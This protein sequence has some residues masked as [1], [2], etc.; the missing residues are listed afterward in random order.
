MRGVRIE[1]DETSS[2]E[3][4]VLADGDLV[5]VTNL[6]RNAAEA[7][8]RTVHLTL[9]ADAARVR[10]EVSDDGPGIPSELLPRI[11]D[12]GVS[13]KADDTGTG[14]GVGLDVVRRMVTR[15]DGTLE[16]GRS[17]LGGARFTFD[18]RTE[19]HA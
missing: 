9:V 2:V 13:T 8:A 6:C 1:L 19:A 14:R 5:V 4:G 10:G 17:T 18:M 11:F 7:G 3:R 12:R 16:V 15:R